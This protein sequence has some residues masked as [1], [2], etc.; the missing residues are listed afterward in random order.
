M[1]GLLFDLRSALRQYARSR[2]LTIVALTSLAV[3]IAVSMAIITAST[4]V[5]VRALPYHKPEDLVMIWG[6]YEPSP[7]L[8]GFWNARELARGELTPGTVL[9]WKDHEL[10]FDNFAVLE[11]WQTGGAAR[12]D[13]VD[14]GHVDHL[15]GTFA[16]SQVFDVFGTQAALGR[17]FS[18]NE[19]DV[20]VLS[21]AL[22]R[23]RFGA[24]S[25]ILGRTLTI[26]MGR[27]HEQR[28]VTIIGVLPK[29]FHVTYPEETE[30][31]FPLTWSDIDRLP[32]FAV[33]YRGVARLRR[34]VSLAT[35]EAH[36]QGLREPSQRSSTTRI[37]LEPMHQYAVGTS[38]ESLL[39][40]LVLG[41][42]VLL[43]GAVNAATVFAA[44]AV[45]RLRE[46]HIRRALGA[47]RARLIRQIFSE[48]GVVG[49]VSGAIGI[50]AISLALPALRAAMPAGLPGVEAMRLDWI[51][52]S[53]V[54]VAVAASTAIA[55]FVPA[56]LCTRARSL[57]TAFES[58]TITTAARG[59]RLR[60]A[61]L[62]MQFALVT[63]L[64]IAGGMS[65]RSFWKVTHVDKGFTA[66][67]EVYVTEIQLLNPAYKDKEFERFEA[68]LLRD[69]R[70]L[71]YV[72]AASIGS[73]IPLRGNDRVVRLRRP[74]GQTMYVNQ[75]NVDPDY[76][77]VMRIP[78]VAGRWLTATDAN[79]S[80]WVALV[81]QSLGEALYP[82]ENPVGKFLEGS[83]GTRI[84]GVVADVRAHSLL[85]APTPVHSIG[86]EHS[87]RR[88]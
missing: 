3:G 82:G 88:I 74:D 87:R 43:S 19:S 68:E 24:D 84:V 55:G 50:G 65:T 2:G 4:A 23:R 47:S 10:P 39:L 61:L 5:L 25:R 34:G 60:M 45:S 66:D 76:F 36:I 22:W 51:T 35:A 41:L 77:K 44:S 20:A 72:E 80:E 21:D 37:W 81:S 52:L 15:R 33:L 16:T 8:A 71:P 30:I 1:T 59:I 6:A 57:D 56:W 42:L 18:E 38:R 67:P 29:G 64:L 7:A 11:S 69:I 27:L 40:V 58:H 78:L 86:R 12:V 28:P 46:M 53:L 9:Q 31:W 14:H 75:R 48:V 79:R 49:L 13:L 26:A 63:V 54:G 32:H 62:G 85:D 83:S 73:A 17:T 70:Q